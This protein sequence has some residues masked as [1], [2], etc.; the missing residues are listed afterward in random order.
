MYDD[1]NQSRCFSFVG[2]VVKAL[3]ELSL[4]DTAVGQVYNVGSDQEISILEL[5]GLVKEMAGSDSPIE[6]IPYDQAYEEGFEDM[7][8]R[9]PD[10]SKIKA[11]IGYEPSTDIRGIISSVIAFE[12]DRS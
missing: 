1:G 11:A 2:D 8:R 10:L 5:A 3:V 4:L 9:V 7:R 12:K 6:L